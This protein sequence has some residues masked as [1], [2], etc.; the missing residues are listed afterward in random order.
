MGS[1]D[2]YSSA[3]QA[4]AIISGTNVSRRGRFPAHSG[5]T[6]TRDPDPLGS[7]ERLLAR[8]AKGEAPRALL[9]EA[10][11]LLE[12]VRAAER[13]R[14]GDELHDGPAQAVGSA[15]LELTR[16][17]EKHPEATLEPAIDRLGRAFDELRAIARGLA[18]KEA[19]AAG[20]ESAIRRVGR[21]L[22]GASGA[23]VTVELDGAA[24]V[25]AG[26]HADLLRFAEEAAA[27]IGRHARARSAR[28]SLE[29]RPGGG[30]LRL[31]DD[32][33]GFRVNETAAAGGLGALARRAARIG[34]RVSIESEPGR[35][36]R[37]EVAWGDAPGNAGARRNGGR[38]TST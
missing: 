9:D 3:S 37:V 30:A 19:G 20:L 16:V 6:P 18:P 22:A 33:V 21:E 28:I 25:P 13:E 15:R 36:T 29:R 10:A 1:S 27:N 38:S 17:A 2:R 5:D 26:A 31:E 24:A 8:A 11:R 34:A 23:E 35:G 7:L 32:G 4:E 14:L 12:E